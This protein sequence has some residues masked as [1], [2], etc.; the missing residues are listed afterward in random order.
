MF[1]EE[2]RKLIVRAPQAQEAALARQE[3]NC[4]RLCA[5]LT[6]ICHGPKALAAWGACVIVTSRSNPEAVLQQLVAD[7]PAAGGAA[8]LPQPGSLSGRFGGALCGLVRG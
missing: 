2:I 3:D 5:R 4:H 8:G 7:N 6:G 1:L